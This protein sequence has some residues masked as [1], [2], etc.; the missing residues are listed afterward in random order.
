M[1]E[2]KDKLKE[3]SKKALELIKTISKEERDLIKEIVE[4]SPNSYMYLGYIPVHT[5]WDNK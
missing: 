2:M 1:R 5:V 3:M 4:T